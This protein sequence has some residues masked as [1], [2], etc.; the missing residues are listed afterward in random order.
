MGEVKAEESALYVSK[1]KDHPTYKLLTAGKIQVH[2]ISKIYKVLSYNV[3]WRY[4]R[5]LHLCAEM[6]HSGERTMLVRRPLMNEGFLL[7]SII[8]NDFSDFFFLS[9]QEQTNKGNQSKL[10]S[11][12]DGLRIIRSN[13]PPLP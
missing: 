9:S 5:S 10:R 13:N 8:L 4:R 11:V 3:S 2:S 12:R 1:S 7:L 6:L